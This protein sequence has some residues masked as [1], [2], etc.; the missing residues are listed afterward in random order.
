MAP[1]DGV[2]AGT[3]SR[4]RSRHRLVFC[5]KRGTCSS[6]ATW[7]RRDGGNGRREE[8]AQRNP[9]VGRRGSRVTALEPVTVDA[10]GCS[11][12]CRHAGRA[13]LHVCAVCRLPCHRGLWTRGVTVHGQPLPCVP[14]ARCRPGGRWWPEAPASGTSPSSYTWEKR[15]RSGGPVGG[16]HEGPLVVTVSGSRDRHCGPRGLAALV[17][18]LLTRPWPRALQA[19]AEGGSR[20]GELWPTWSETRQRRLHT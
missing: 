11:L 2:T 8:R 5:L 4:L 19:L 14:G 18:G 10:G 12:C 7:T 15:T 17:L 13:A 20:P 1:R 9:R 3:P 16:P 6:Q